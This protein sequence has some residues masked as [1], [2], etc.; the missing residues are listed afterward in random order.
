VL[1]K[2]A[3]LIESATFC[4]DR[5]SDDRAARISDGRAD[6]NRADRLGDE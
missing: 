1:I 2:S 6:R 5:I 3:T 4:A